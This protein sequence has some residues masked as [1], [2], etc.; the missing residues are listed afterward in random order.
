MTD[1]LS[2]PY[3]SPPLATRI[4][5]V[6]PIFEAFRPIQYLGNKS[7]LVAQIE[8]IMKPFVPPGGR[9]GDLFSGTCVVGSKL[10]ASRPVTAVDVQAYASLLARAMLLGQPEHLAF[11]S[12]PDFWDRAE[13][14][15][16]AA[17][18]TFL[19]L[20]SLE[21]DALSAAADGCVNQLVGIIENGSVASFM[22][23]PSVPP[24]TLRRRL[25]SVARKFGELGVSHASCLAAFYYGG[26]YFSYAP[27][28][29]LGA[30]SAA[31]STAPKVAQ[32]VLTAALLS[33][34]S[35]VANTV[36][37]QFAQPIRLLKGDGQPQPLL[38]ERTLRDRSLN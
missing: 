14:A 23:R 30:L 2:L 28:I 1:Q 9:I 8:E 19:P 34:A 18:S 4:A 21:A 32:P 15:A 5:P 25:R 22:Q 3:S 31:I 33:T 6:A 38:V 16:T 35:Q 12:K 11:G 13:S 10:A 24:G 27:A 36:G 29:A 7:R 37:K 20:L 17:R 26:V